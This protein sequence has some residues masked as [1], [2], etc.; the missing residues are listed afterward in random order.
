M[1]QTTKLHKIEVRNKTPDKVQTGASTEVLIDG[2]PFKGVTFLKFEVKAKG[3]AR[4]TVELFA[5]IDI[6]SDVG[7]EIKQT[8][9]IH[10]SHQLG[11]YE[12]AR[13]NKNVEGVGEGKLFYGVVAPYKGVGEPKLIL[14][15]AQLCEGGFAY[16]DGN[17]LV[18][19]P[20][21]VVRN[22]SETG[23]LPIPEKP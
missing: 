5:D 20:N 7:I 4:C 13:I 18:V 23:N 22:V 11:D 10:A 1:S 8:K 19:D 6:A 16:G 21:S 9:D 2:K 17:H 14:H 12:P 15:E 3:L